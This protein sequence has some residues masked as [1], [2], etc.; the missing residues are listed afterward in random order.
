MH[1]YKEQVACLCCG[2]PMQL[3]RTV[4]HD[5]L[6]EMQTFECKKC[7]LAVTAGA[8]LSITEMAAPLVHNQRP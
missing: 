5:Y 6:P 1:E 4:P 7:R 3:A 8:V 2:E